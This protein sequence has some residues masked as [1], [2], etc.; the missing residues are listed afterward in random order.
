M[1]KIKA[2][3]DQKLLDESGAEAL[4][5][6]MRSIFD[7]EKKADKLS[8]SETMDAKDEQLANMNSIIYDLAIKNKFAT[9]PHFSGDSPV[10]I[11]Q[12]DD[13]ALI[14]GKNFKTVIT[15]RDLDVVPIDD[16]GAE[17]LSKKNHGKTATFTEAIAQIIEIKSKEKPILR[18]AKT[19]GPMTSG[20]TGSNDLNSTVGSGRD[21]IKAG[22]VKYQQGRR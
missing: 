13:A 11:Y 16:S 3:G 4:K 15:G 19:G 8:Y 21:R 10:T 14:Y 18:N 2:I 6:N 1:E 12:P 17:I 5:S 22:L 20:N 7:E 9:D